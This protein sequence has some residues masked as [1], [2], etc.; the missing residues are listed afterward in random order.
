MKI[1]DAG[2]KYEV[3]A[4]DGGEPQVIQFVKRC[5]EGFPFNASESGGTNCQEVLRI[6]I[7]RVDYLQ[8]QKPC[9]ESEAISSLLKTAL[10]LFEVRAARNHG[11][12][13]AMGDL[14]Q[15]VREKPCGKCGHVGC[16]KH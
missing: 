5:G 12:T 10:L 1:L 11:H 3:D 8:R 9:A 15:C 14:M 4:L 7:D 16:E 2:H 6:L 13:L